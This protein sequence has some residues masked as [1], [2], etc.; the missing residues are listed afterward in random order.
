M[1]KEKYHLFQAEKSDTRK[2]LFSEFDDEDD[3]TAEVQVV[4]KP[5]PKPVQKS[6]LTEEK[7]I[8]STCIKIKKYLI[9]ILF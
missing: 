1:K 8:V 2:R 6:I 7:Q 4:K 5:S 9:I 3:I